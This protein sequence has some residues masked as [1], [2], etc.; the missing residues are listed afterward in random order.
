MFYE[1]S[2]FVPCTRGS[3]CQELGLFGQTAL[4]S[5]CSALAAPLLGF[6]VFLDAF[7]PKLSLGAK[8]RT[9]LQNLA[10]LE[11]AP[12]QLFELLS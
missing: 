3:P 9:L 4:A 11:A 7:V 12:E 8:L 1:T 10:S 5:Q 2:R 6:V